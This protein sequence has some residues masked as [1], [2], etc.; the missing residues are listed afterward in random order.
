MAEV[1]GLNV[2]LID[3]HL[4]V[5]APDHWV[6]GV[7]REQTSTIIHITSVATIE[8]TLRLL[9]SPQITLHAAIP[10]MRQTV[11][12]VSSAIFSAGQN[13]SLLIDARVP[14][15]LL[16]ETP[17]DEERI[18]V[19]F[20][21]VIPK[22]Q[23]TPLLI[24]KTIAFVVE[25]CQLRAQIN[26]HTSRDRQAADLAATQEQATFIATL[27]D[28]ARIMSSSLNPDVVMT[29]I[30]HHL[31]R[32]I[33]HDSASILLVKDSFAEMTYANERNS[34]YSPEARRATSFPLTIS[35][36]AE[37]IATHKPCLIPDTHVA[38]NWI[39][40][41]TQT[42]IRSYVGVPI[43]VN[44]QVFGFLGIDSAIPNFFTPIHADRLQSLADHAA[45]AVQNAQ[46]YE[47]M[48]R[49]AED[50]KILHRASSFLRVSLRN[51]S[52]VEE[53]AKY[54][55][56]AIASEFDSIGC[57]IFA[58]QEDRTLVRIANAGQ[59]ATPVNRIMDID[60]PLGLIAQSV[61]EA[62]TVYSPDVIT[63]T[64][65]IVGHP[66]TR[67]ELIIP[68]ELVTGT[69]GVLDIQSSVTNA[70]DEADIRILS[71]P[72]QVPC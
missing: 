33:P 3:P 2:V 35:T 13:A 60:G 7:I 59:F 65:Y 51:T 25:R 36:F 72:N 71:D 23:A 48:R 32:I 10:Q 16:L 40:V 21:E 26:Q 5:N 46:L 50:L 57:S 24:Q 12:L 8:D 61:R 63:D 68:L 44:N 47:Q 62:K 53:I 55:V 22:D 52:S 39:K 70:F 38:P 17:Q 15:V 29:L 34:D 11:L 56:Q 30:L 58:L 9:H 19:P 49:D 14:V 69:F 67:S 37:M 41:P 43:L 54:I 45:I 6:T 20:D 64:R 4:K 27:R 66:A 42:W 1:T 18:D 28:I 31:R